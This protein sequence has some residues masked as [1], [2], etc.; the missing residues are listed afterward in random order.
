ML[1][2]VLPK[3]ENNFS[4]MI[5][6]SRRSGKTTLVK[7]MLDNVY[8][9]QFD[10]IYIFYPMDF[11]QPD[12]PYRGYNMKYGKHISEYSNEALENIIHKLE[13]LRQQIPTIKTLIVLDDCIS[14]NEFKSCQ[15][16]HPLNKLGI[17]GRHLGVSFIITSQNYASIPKILRNNVDVCILIPGL[18]NNSLFLNEK[19]VFPKKDK[20]QQVL[21][22]CYSQPH[23]Y[24]LLSVFHRDKVIVYKGN[25][26][27]F[28]EIK[29]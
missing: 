6:G 13:L 24:I 27:Q 19:N 29:P 20:F 23:S 21:S 4:C 10:I 2:E 28:Y 9:G 12:H 25:D 15:A 3:A 14:E 5:T 26:R 16:S 11:R 17:R 1:R 18:E 22:M 8:M 7:N